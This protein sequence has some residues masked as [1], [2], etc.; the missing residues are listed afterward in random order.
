MNKK[1]Q[2]IERSEP[3]KH[4]QIEMTEFQDLDL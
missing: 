3:V 2:R 4:K 1:K